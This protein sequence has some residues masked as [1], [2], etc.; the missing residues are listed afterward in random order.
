MYNI[1][2]IC[3]YWLG[4]PWSGDQIDQIDEMLLDG[5]WWSIIEAEMGFDG[6]SIYTSANASQMIQQMLHWRW[7]MSL[8]L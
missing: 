6:I 4:L 8:F 7:N 3:I 5:Q 2:M 1:N